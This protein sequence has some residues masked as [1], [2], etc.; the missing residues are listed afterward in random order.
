M[1]VHDVLTN[2]RI[3]ELGFTK[4]GNGNIPYLRLPLWLYHGKTPRRPLKT[5][6]PC[7]MYHLSL[8]ACLHLVEP[9]QHRIPAVR[10]LSPSLA[11]IPAT[12]NLTTS[13]A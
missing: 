9:E 13:I 4:K 1:Y 11:H 5:V 2:N 12:L 8:L 6:G 3:K 10:V 7:Q